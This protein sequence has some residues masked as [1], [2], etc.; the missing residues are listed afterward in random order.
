[1]AA[2]ASSLFAS[3]AGIKVASSVVPQSSRS[4]DQTP[5]GVAE[6]LAVTIVNELWVFCSLAVG[7]R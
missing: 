3:C 1:M 4:L 6:G 5:A 7:P 2:S